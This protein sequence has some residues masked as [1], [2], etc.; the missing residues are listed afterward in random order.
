GMSGAGTAPGAPLRE[1][2]RYRRAL[3]TTADPFA[4]PLV[5]RCGRLRRPCR[6]A[7]PGRTCAPSP[8]RYHPTQPGGCAVPGG[9]RPT[10]DQVAPLHTE[11]TATLRG[12][13]AVDVGP[14]AASKET[15]SWHSDEAASSRS[16]S[17][18]ILG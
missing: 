15:N 2:A 9:W 10:A 18:S 14:R 4:L 5:V 3:S 7:G 11:N 12:V 1:L 13:Q 16:P 6:R 8:L 17:W